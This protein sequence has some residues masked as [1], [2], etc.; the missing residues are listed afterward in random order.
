MAWKR[1]VTDA[2]VG[3][4]GGVAAL[5]GATRVLADGVVVGGDQVVGPQQG[6]V[7][8]PVGGFNIDVECRDSVTQILAALRSHC[9]ITPMPPDSLGTP[10]RASQP[11]FSNNGIE[12]PTQGCCSHSNHSR[13]GSRTKSSAHRGE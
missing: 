9:L 12:P 11:H 2:D 8:D 6:P 13:V 7:P 4:A 1:Q 10:L 3:V 5:D